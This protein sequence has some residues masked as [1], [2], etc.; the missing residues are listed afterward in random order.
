MR[1][2]CVLIAAVVLAACAKQGGGGG[3]APQPDAT[4]VT[5]RV[6]GGSGQMSV[7]MTSN[8][9]T[10]AA[11]V[12]APVPKAWDAL[13]DVY[14]ELGLAATQIDMGRHH[15]ATEGLKVR[16]RLGSLLLRQLL[17]CGD[18]GEGPKAETYDITLTVQTTVSAQ[19]DGSQLSTLV[20]A[21]GKSPTSNNNDVVCASVGK[22]EEEIAK[23]VTGRVKPAP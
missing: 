18:G 4:P 17:D 10:V 2:T 13:V 19:G 21:T 3:S 12:P 23:R 1:Y 15:I 14:K 6:I 8:A 20:T 5:T 16:R 7:N 11:K 22:L 9:A